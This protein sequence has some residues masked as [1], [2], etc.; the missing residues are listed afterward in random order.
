M[1]SAEDHIQNIEQMF[2]STGGAPT[3]E[4]RIFVH[5]DDV[6]ASLRVDL[7]YRTGHLL[8]AQLAIDTRHNRPVWTTYSF[9][10]VDAQK[11]CV[12]RYDNYDHHRELSTAPHHKHVGPDEAVREHFQPSIRHIINE[13]YGF[14]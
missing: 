12:F 6:E 14:V 2:L 5:P 10:F 3:M 11:A 1:L 9:Q 13:I 4:S 7:T 8:S